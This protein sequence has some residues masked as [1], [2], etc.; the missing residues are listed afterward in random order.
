MPSPVSFPENTTS[1][2]TQTVTDI[3]QYIKWSQK[4]SRNFG[5]RSG[6]LL[7]WFRGH[8]K[9]THKLKPSLYRCEIDKGMERELIRDFKIMAAEY[10]SPLTRTPI[11][12]LF[13]AQHYGI[14]TR[15]LDWSENPLVA[16]FFAT[17][18]SDAE[19]HVW[20]LN[21]WQL[22]LATI[23]LGSV[24][25]TDSP[26]FANYVIDIDNINV[27]R[28]I[29]ASEPMAIRPYHVFSR[30]NAQHGVFTIHG[31]KEKSI[32]TNNFVRRNRSA[33]LQ[34]AVIPKEAKN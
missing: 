17:S 6:T 18:N 19:G 32:D 4:I 13:I 5:L 23:S 1:I 7:P 14:P 24:P 27:E 10:L 8:S 28:K 12:W 20:A 2:I 34:R 30:L 33:C 31:S 21:A 3:D 11:D 9:D 29:V 25:T 16:L 22:N 15:L 26:F